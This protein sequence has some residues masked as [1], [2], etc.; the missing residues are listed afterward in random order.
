MQSCPLYLQG[1]LC[2]EV[3]VKQAEAEKK[4]TCTAVYF[5]SGSF[6]CSL[7]FF[8]LLQSGSLDLGAEVTKGMSLPFLSI[9]PK[10]L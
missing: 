6:I 4:A 9:L 3:Q 1:R 10:H 7:P 5:P 8:F 2:L